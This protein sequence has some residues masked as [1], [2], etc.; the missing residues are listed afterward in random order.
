LFE[1]LSKIGI[2][3][4]GDWKFSVLGSS[5]EVIM[6]IWEYV[7]K[8]MCYEK[9]VLNFV[10]LFDGKGSGLESIRMTWV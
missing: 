3:S 4:S 8:I 6:R 9:K 7:K 1:S 10:L 2:V 5:L